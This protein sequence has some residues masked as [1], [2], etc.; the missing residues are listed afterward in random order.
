MCC[1]VTLFMIVVDSKEI[2]RRRRR[3]KHDRQPRVASSKVKVG[4]HKLMQSYAVLHNSRTNLRGMGQSFG[5]NRWAE[6]FADP[7]QKQATL[8]I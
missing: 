1:Q 8:F 6:A 4:M 7:F 5:L 2:E 3:R